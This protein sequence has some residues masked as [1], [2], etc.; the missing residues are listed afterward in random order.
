MSFQHVPRNDLCETTYRENLYFWYFVLKKKQVRIWK[1]HCA[2][3]A[4]MIVR[5]HAMQMPNI[6]G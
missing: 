6:I 3:W 4:E 5:G 1:L 2:W